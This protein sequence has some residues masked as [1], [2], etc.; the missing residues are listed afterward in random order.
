MSAWKNRIEA[1]FETLAVS[2]CRHP[3][4]Y[5]LAVF[6]L[7]A[8]IATQL[9]KV[10][11]DTSTEGFLSPGHPA[12]IEY[13]EF[14]D[15]FGRDELLVV[16]VDIPQFSQAF[17]KQFEALFRQLDREVPHTDSVESILTARH[18]YGVEDEL[19]V[20][21]LFEDWPETDAELAQLKQLIETHPL[22][23]GFFVSPDLSM[24]TIVIR[25]RY[26][27]TEDHPTE[28]DRRSAVDKQISEVLDHVYG[29][30]E[31]HR[32]RGLTIYLAGSPTIVD[33]LKRSTLSDMQLFVKLVV[34]IIAL[35]LFLLFRRLSAVVLPLLTVMLA[36][37]TTISLMAAFGQPIQL[38]TAIVPSFLLAVGG[39][40]F[41]PLSDPVLPPF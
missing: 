17:F 28:G 38:P 7:V 8:A 30:I 9:A 31:Q 36:V 35:V 24:A 27:H 34:G 13:N 40:G 22:Y 23:K 18:V 29:V 20:E 4:W 1:G 21:D 26:L 6:A 15:I 10:Y 37:V 3:V 16:G 5:L 32:A 25:L 2:I 11:F 14:R 41:H 19:V 33:L 12:I 39:W